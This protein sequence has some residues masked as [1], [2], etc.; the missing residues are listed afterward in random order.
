MFRKLAAVFDTEAWLKL[1]GG[2][3]RPAFPT[4]KEVVCY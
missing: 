2:I 4:R 3:R 1:L